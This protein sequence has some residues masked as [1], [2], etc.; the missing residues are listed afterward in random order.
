MQTTPEMSV[1]ALVMNCLAPLITQSPLSRRA[2]VR[3][4][5]GVRAR[6]R[7][8]Q[9]EGA[10][11]AARGQVRQPLLLLLLRPEQVDR[12]RPERRVRAHRDRHRGVDARELLDGDRVGQRVAARAAVL[13]GERDPHQPELAELGDDLVR[14]ALLAVERL[15]DR[16]HLALGEVADGAA[17]QLMVGRRGRSPCGHS[18]SAPLEVELVRPPGF[19]ES[20]YHSGNTGPAKSTIPVLIGG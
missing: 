8:G 1:P 17:D 15:G 12:L 14:E 19:S 16:R 11:L 3:T 13:L 2:R 7:L 9:P 20:K 18:V 4:L 10:E 5:P 6:L